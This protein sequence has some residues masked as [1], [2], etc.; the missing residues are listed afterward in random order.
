M[1]VSHTKIGRASGIL[2]HVTSLPGKFGIGDFGPES[3]AFIDTLVEA[4]QK[5]WCVLPLNPTGDEN[6][7]YQC[8]SAFA[9][10]PLLISPELLVEHGYLSAKELRSPPHFP[11]RRVDFAPV[12]SY[13]EALL[14]KAF[15]NFTET[16]E[17]SR[18]ERTNSAW[19][20]DYAT[21]TAL[22][23]ANGGVPWTKFRSNTKPSPQTVRYH[24][25][26]Q[27]EFFRQW[28]ALREYCAKQKLSIMGDMPFYVEHNS[29]DVWSNPSLFDLRKDGEPRTVGGVPPDYFSRDG[30]LW[31]TPAYR[32]EKLK[33]TGFQ[34]WI[35]RFRATL[36]VVDLL[37]LDHFR[38]F[39]A[40]WS[41]AADQ[42]T[43]RKG[44]WIKGPGAE[45]FEKARRELGDLPFIAENLGTITS[46]VEQLRQGFNLPG[47]AVLQF[48]FDESGTHRPDNCVRAQVCFTG[49]HDNDTTLGWWRAVQRASRGKN[50]D[51]RAV[52]NRVKS[53]LQTNGSEI[54]WS[55]MQ[56]ILTSVADIA[57][58]PLQDVLGLGS[59]ARMNL[60]GRAKGNWR[61]RFEK[62]QIQPAALERLRDLTIV[63]G[64]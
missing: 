51:A 30:Q 36:E 7:P 63:S 61:W 46:E 48:G 42:T 57:I 49:T 35:E 13:K 23:A 22:R 45:L 25:F 6:S 39:E 2:L 15:K 43:A 33:Q 32:W 1:P 10:N 27:Y 59:E 28:H 8:R 58:I 52:E 9:G 56:A 60:P 14:E 12:R 16:K 55:F 47:M 26:V 21:F 24:K 38:G 40:F 17:Y 37:R 50:A 29:A 54:H 53:Y 64:R 20:E 3:R 4:K 19:L 31:G 34:W 18:F 5:L 11:A 44:R 62:E 41:V